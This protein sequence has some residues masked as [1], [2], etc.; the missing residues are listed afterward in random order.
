[1]NRISSPARRSQSRSPSTSPRWAVA[2]L[3]RVAP[4]GCWPAPAARW[5]ARAPR[6]GRSR[7]ARRRG[8]PARGPRSG[9]RAGRPRP[10]RP[11]AASRVRN[12]SARRRPAAAGIG[13]GHRTTVP[14]PRRPGHRR[15]LLRRRGGWKTDQ[16]TTRRTSDLGGE[17]REAGPRAEQPRVERDR[18]RR[19]A[20]RVARHQ[21]G[22]PLAPGPRQ[23]HRPCWP[24]TNTSASTI[25]S[26]AAV[27]RT[28]SPTAGGEQ[29]E[30]GQVEPAAE[31]RAQ[32]AVVGERQADA[33]AVEEP[34]AARGT[35]ANAVTVPTTNS[36][37]AEH[38]RLGRQHRAAAAGSRPA[39]RGS[40]RCRTRW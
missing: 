19:P 17:H 24:T 15:G 25:D 33:L 1:M 2:Q 35:P 27:C 30:P 26:A 21:L 13:G 22:D 18:R 40:S 6:R 28:S 39:S 3:R 32:H 11:S 5:A 8:R 36:V 14:R 38:E 29:P 7:S 16:P 20:T 37:A 23:Q 10:R 34:V 31:Q 9:R 4:G 12:S